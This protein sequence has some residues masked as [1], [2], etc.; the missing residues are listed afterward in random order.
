MRTTKATTVGRCWAQSASGVG[1]SAW[2]GRPIGGVAATDDRGFDECNFNSA[3]V[4][5]LDQHD[6]LDGAASSSMA[7]SDAESKPPSR[8]APRTAER[9]IAVQRRRRHGDKYE[10]ARWRTA[11]AIRVVSVTVLRPRPLPIARAPCP[12]RILQGQQSLNDQGYDA[13]KVVVGPP[14]SQRE[15]VP[16]RPASA[17]QVA[18]TRRPSRRRHCATRPFGDDRSAV[19]V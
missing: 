9:P 6:E 19:V 18:S 5:E 11:A 13:G 3:H 8:T 1:Q 17:L 4:L 15:E 14:T 2:L 16:G 12:V 7:A 10:D